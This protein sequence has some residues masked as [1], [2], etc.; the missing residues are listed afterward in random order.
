MIL[1]EWGVQ[2]DNEKAHGAVF[3][4]FDTNAEYGL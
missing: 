2:V 4:L 3:D 1:A